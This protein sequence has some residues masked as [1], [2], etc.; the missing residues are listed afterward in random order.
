MSYQNLLGRFGLGL[1]LVLSLA[2]C[3][4]TESTDDGDGPGTTL[5]NGTVTITGDVNTSIDGGAAF[6]DGGEGFDLLIAA[7]DFTIPFDDSSDLGDEYLAISVPEALRTGTITIDREAEVYVEYQRPEGDLYARS[8]TIT[9]TEASNE[10]LVGTISAVVGRP[11]S[12]STYSST[13][14]MQAS[15]EALPLGI[16]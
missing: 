8:G 12:D 9:I 3:D 4:T 5:G 1:C 11:T 2:A 6:Y 14:E 10:R 15:F 13:A 7:Y 16:D